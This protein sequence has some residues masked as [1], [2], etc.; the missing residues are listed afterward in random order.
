[1]EFLFSKNIPWIDVYKRQV[2]GSA[3]PVYALYEREREA[4]QEVFEVVGK[5]A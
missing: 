5:T 2:D 3:H 1:M 4:S